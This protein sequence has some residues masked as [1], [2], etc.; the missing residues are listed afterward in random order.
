MSDH[1]PALRQGVRVML[2]DDGVA[3][4]LEDGLSNPEGSL[5]ITLSPGR[6]LRVAACLVRYA[7]RA[8]PVGRGVQAQT[9]TAS[10]GNVER[11]ILDALNRHRPVEFFE[12]SVEFDT[13]IVSCTCGLWRGF[14]SVFNAHRARVIAR[15]DLGPPGGDGGGS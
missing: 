7:F 2:V 15:G 1:D 6:A 9:M 13:G 8:A 4:R 11:L 5:T 14:G 12:S 10:A 3:L